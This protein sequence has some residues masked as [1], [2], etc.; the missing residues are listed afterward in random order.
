LRQLSAG[1][2][3]LTDDFPQR[4]RPVAARPS[5]SDPRYP[6]DP[7]VVAM[8]RRALDP[9]RARDA[10]AT[11][12]F[13]KRLWPPALLAASLQR[14]DQQRIINRVLWEGGQPL[15]QI[16]DLHALLVGTSLRTLPLWLLGSDDV[17]ERIAETSTERSSATDYASA[18]RALVARDYRR[19][20]AYFGE[21]ERRGLR[22]E[23]VR[24]LQVYSLC[25]AGDLDTARLLARGVVARSEAA[26]H[27]WGWLRTTFDVQP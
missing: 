4:L 25:L 12:D 23:A 21:S 19:A 27:F 10:F 6:A 2:P 13:V 15:A 9:V 1:A 3:P 11:S 26:R 17:K 8:Y 7:A 14:F 5:L 18:L 20:A 24:P 22:A 16:E